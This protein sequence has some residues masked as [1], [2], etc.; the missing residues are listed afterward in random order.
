MLTVIEQLEQLR[1]GGLADV[2]AAASEDELEAVRVAVLGKKGS[3][4]AILRGL[5]S[6][7]ATERPAVGKTANVVR[8]ELESALEA[9]RVELSAAAMQA[10]IEAGRLDVTLPGR[11]RPLGSQHLIHRLRDEIIDVF[12]GIGYRVA[13]GPEIEL[14]FF[15]FTALNHE[16]Q[17][18]ARSASDTFY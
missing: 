12:S 2:A 16:P 6:L 9:R 13:E 18:P 8:R 14:D 15:N 10:S 4:T 5:G 3:L 11:A 7:S 1:A 17:H